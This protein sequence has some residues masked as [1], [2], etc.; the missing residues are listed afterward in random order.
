[1]FRNFI[2]DDTKIVKFDISSHNAPT[3]VSFLETVTSAFRPQRSF[4]FSVRRVLCFPPEFTQ[5]WEGRAHE[6]SLPCSG[7]IRIRMKVLHFGD[8]F[9]LLWETDNTPMAQILLRCIRSLS[10]QSHYYDNHR[11]LL[12]SI[13]TTS[14]ASSRT[15]CSIIIF[16]ILSFAAS[17]TRPWTRLVWIGSHRGIS[18]STLHT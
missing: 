4:L 11:K 7:R 12:I 9:S 14:F 13:F 3:A 17:L 10:P 2:T 18:H 5:T 16:I 6:R 15:L 8:P 1:M